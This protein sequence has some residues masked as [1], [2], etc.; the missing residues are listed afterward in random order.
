MADKVPKLGGVNLTIGGKTHTEGE[1]RLTPPTGTGKVSTSSAIKTAAESRVHS[2]TEQLTGTGIKHSTENTSITSE[3]QRTPRTV[4]G[5]KTAAE[6]KTPETPIY[7]PSV[8]GSAHTPGR[9]S[10]AT[11]PTPRTASPQT[12]PQTPTTGV[13]SLPLTPRTASPGSM[14]VP[15][16]PLTGQRATGN[17]Q[18][19]SSIATAAETRVHSSTD[20]YRSTDAQVGGKTSITSEVNRTPRTVEAVKT[21]MTGKGAAS[22]VT[23]Q[24]LPVA[25]ARPI[26]RRS[27]ED[28][29]GEGQTQTVS[30]YPTA[31][32]TVNAVTGNMLTTAQ[33]LRTAN[34]L[35][36]G[37]KVG[38][39]STSGTNITGTAAKNIIQRMSG[40]MIGYG[41]AAT[42]AGAVGNATPGAPGVLTVRTGG[43]GAASA[44]PLGTAQAVQVMSGAGAAA[45]LD[46]FMQNPT[47]L[48]D[49]VLGTGKTGL[50]A[51]QGRMEQ[52]GDLGT[53]SVGQAMSLAQTA[54]LSFRVSQK[55][56]EIAPQAGKEIIKTGSTAARATY[57][58]ATTAG[59]ATVTL[60]KSTAAIARGYDMTGKVVV[61]VP[62]DLANVL[63]RYS[64]VTGLNQTTVS[65]AIVHRVQAIQTGFHAGIAKF[66]TG[67]AYTAKTVRGIV[68]QTEKA[69]RIVHGVT[70]GTVSLAMV[71]RNAAQQLRA[72][73]RVIRTRAKAG[74]KTGAKALKRGVIRGGGVLVK[75]APRGIFTAYKGG[76]FTV[77][78]VATIGAGFLTGT[79]DYA[80]QGLGHAA[81][82][83][84]LGVKTSV[85]A[86]KLAGKAGGYT[87]KTGVKGVKTARAGYA[88]IKNR[89]LRAAF[90]QARKKVGMKI[91][92]AGRSLVSA[93][94]NLVK[95]VGM[96]IAVPLILI[97]AIA[98]GFTAAISVPA[99]AIG[100]ILGGIFNMDGTG[101]DVE[102]R[103]YLSDP[104]IGVP[105]LV[106]PLKADILSEVKTALN[107]TTN[108]NIIRFK[109]DLTGA[110]TFL[111]VSESGGVVTITN[112]DSAF[113]DNDQIISMLQPLFNA[114]VLMNYDLAPTEAQAKDTLDYMF[115][116]MF[117][118]ENKDTE[119]K[120]GQDLATGEGRTDPDGTPHDP[121]WNDPCTDCGEIHALSDCPN[122]VTGTHSSYTCP[123]CCYR[124]CGGHE[125]EV[126]DGSDP[127]TGEA[128]SHTETEYRGDD[129]CWGCG[130]YTHCGGHKVKTF[131][132]AVDG[133][134]TLL[135]EYFQQ[136]INSLSAIPEASRT[137]AQKEQLQMLKD[138]LEIF[139]EMVNQMG[140]TYGVNMAGNLTVADLADVVFDHSTRRGCQ[141]V[142]NTAL[143]QV[144][145]SGGRPFWQYYGFT[146]RVE[147]CA[148]FV[149]W[150][151]HN[152]PYT[153]G[154][155]PTTSN[156][157]L[158]QTVADNFKSIGQWGNRGYTDMVAGDTIFFDWEGDGH[159]DHIG[160]V[161]GRSGNSVYTVEG[162]SGD[163]VRIKSYDVNSSVIYGYGLMDYNP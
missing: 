35:G 161:I 51:L 150:C 125:V 134:Y 67:Y 111:D 138:Y 11:S 94:I 50:V 73:G 66:K 162:N 110:D 22:P 6:P 85:Q 64:A 88:F 4:E 34:Q 45:C 15:T 56:T 8:P 78:N 121:P 87:V 57:Q 60:A 44:V 128:L 7:K 102:V 58:V 163:M 86:G 39:L 123:T 26:T 133:I 42:V 69:V 72:A 104:S 27:A 82:A 79:D 12:T 2:S 37:Y 77:K 154:R 9:G 54:Y 113:P 14:E 20:Y 136:P 159:T 141:E 30:P 90:E 107:D 38:H 117:K 96:K 89:G 75:N 47:G 92:E 147:W 65:K 28:S 68:H 156:N 29:A 62:R 157:A 91:V 71:S 137:E 158:C 52:A 3:T 151:M 129:C 98:G 99:S 145:L 142:I 103:D 155:Y 32:L 74:I 127:V 53:E 153:M 115:S 17:V 135:D 108:N 5:I 49:T 119:E 55:V 84:Q 43:R 83:V 63:K 109:S 144:G 46:R 95:T 41:T 61:N 100:A 112:F 93:A 148:C 106:P 120:C 80:L 132:L 143:G 59:K 124:Y 160:L 18:T 101:D 149:H 21:G 81:N 33:R 105:A 76:K 126:S 146:E 48:K 131:T 118:L 16:S 36:S 97:V 19:A 10:V 31:R 40:M 122:T 23:K 130:G 1:I 24:P 25:G 140:E 114:V 70:T 152:T 13:S 116:K 139:W